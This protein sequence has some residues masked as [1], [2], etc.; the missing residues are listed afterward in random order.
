MW[1]KGF[2]KDARQL[3]IRFYLLALLIFLTF[4]GSGLIVPVVPLYAMRLGAGA[5]ELGL[6]I[7]GAAISRAVAQPVLGGLSDR[8]GR[9]PLIVVAQLV[10]AEVSFLYTV[11]QSVW[12]VL[13]LRFIQGIALASFIVSSRALVADVTTPANRGLA[14][15]ISSTAQTSGFMLGPAIGGGLASFASLEWPFYL[16]TTVSLISGLIGIFALPGKRLIVASVA[17]I[18]QVSLS[19]RV[20]LLATFGLPQLFEMAGLGVYMT[21]FVPFVSES[22]YWPPAAIG[23][24]FTLSAVGG[25]VAGPLMGHLSDKIGRRAV[26]FIGLGLI[27]TQPILIFLAADTPFIW[28]AFLIGGAG[29]PAYFDAL[30]SAVGDATD[31]KNRAW[32]LGGIGAIGDLGTALGGLTGQFIW[33]SIGIRS[34]FLFDAL[35]VAT[36]AAAVSLTWKRRESAL[37]QKE[38]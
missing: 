18:P 15:G 35:L 33:Q 24:S 26:G 13:A 6:L 20:S 21:V 25:L 36:A 31:P 28:L 7:A 34:A 12:V 22:L 2:L 14:N 38:A 37:I 30:F 10:N 8:W 9:K 11:T 3:S 19:S 27:F 29:G 5:L 17:P 1:N 16:L 23:L 32:V 4:A